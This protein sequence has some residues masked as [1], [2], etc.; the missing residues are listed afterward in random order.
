MAGPRLAARSGSGAGTRTVR[1]VSLKYDGAAH[2]SYTARL[3]GEDDGGSWLGVRADAPVL[4]GLRRVVRREPWVLYIPSDGWWTAMF[5]A[6]PRP[7]EI[8]CDITTPATWQGAGEVTVVDLDLDVR[9]RRSGEIDLKDEDEFAAHRVR[10]GYPAEVVRR[11]RQAARWLVGAL[12]DGT[13]P[14]AGGYRPWLDQV[15]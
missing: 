12:S 8:Y 3:L 11:A 15:L 14:F 6:E 4:V 9:R 1:V 2:R 7:S 5:N 13:Q 10:Y